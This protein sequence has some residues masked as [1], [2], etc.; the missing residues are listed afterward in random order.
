MDLQNVTVQDCMDMCRYKNK[1]VVISAGNI[2]GFEQSSED[3]IEELIAA[4]KSERVEKLKKWLS[5]LAEN[6]KQQKNLKNFVDG[7]I[8]C[9]SA[10]I[11]VH[12]SKG[13]REVADMLCL[14]CEGK[15]FD[16]S[17]GK[18]LRLRFFWDE[19]EFFGWEDYNA[20]NG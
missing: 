10:D 3:Y 6:F 19:V 4:I 9:A 2:L 8:S 12:L 15:L 20:G 1:L 11:G 13:V 16:T 14:P 7:S 17:S 5:A 18:K